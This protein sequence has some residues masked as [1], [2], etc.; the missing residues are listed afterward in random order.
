M[1]LVQDIIADNGLPVTGAYLR[2]ERW[3]AV[4]NTLIAFD[5]CGYV[6]STSRT[7]V[8]NETRQCAFDLDGPNPAAQAYL[9]C[10]TLPEFAGAVDA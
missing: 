6:N 1:A 8:F 7:A 3:R 2:V 9:Y 10:K 5:V 4:T